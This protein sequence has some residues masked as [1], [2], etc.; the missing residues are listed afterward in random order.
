M[1]WMSTSLARKILYLCCCGLSFSVE[2]GPA[3]MP[4]WLSGVCSECAR[5]GKTG[6]FI[7]EQGEEAL[8]ARAW[9]SRRTE[10][11]IDVQY[12]IWSV[13]NVGTLAASELYKAAER[14]VMVRVIVDDFMLSISEDTLLLLAAHPNINIK[15][16]NPNINIGQNVF[17]K[18]FNGLK[19]FRGV[20]QRMHDKAAIFDGAVGITGGRNMADEYFDFD[21]Q[22][23]FR[24]RDVLLVGNVVTEMQ[25]HFEVFWGSELAK[26]ISTLFPRED[27]SENKV[28][29]YFQFLKAYS[30]SADNFAPEVQRAISEL[31]SSL[32]LLSQS[33]VW[34]DARYIGDVPGKNQSDSLGGS[35]VTT[36]KLVNLIENARESVLIQSPYLVFPEEG[37][38]LLKRAAERGVVIKISTNSLQ[39]TDNVMAYSGYY[40]QKQKLLD[41]GVELFEFKPDAKNRRALSQRAERNDT[42]FSLHAKSMVV[43]GKTAFIGSF[44]LDPRSANL[45]TEVG[46]VIHNPALA[47]ELAES[48]LKDMATENSWAVTNVFDPHDEASF[49]QRVKT[50]SFS[51]L[52]IAPVL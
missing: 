15:I 11:T 14:G 25:A 1:K 5:G 7:L 52:P 41:I 35:G 37:L 12:F 29:Q 23:N 20:N 44:N 38:G 30:E 49:G 45:N 6:V 17:S 27:V 24:D 3:Q 47:A 28:S 40:N 22:Y 51:L 39:S 2:A 46:V 21:H 26:S 43:D 9:L 32:P 10:K 34:A 16:Y 18:F 48:I 50:W 19:D 4:A 33:L 36:K 13:D 31:D 42:V 8:L